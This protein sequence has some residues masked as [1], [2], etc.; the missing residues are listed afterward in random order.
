VNISP[1]RLAF[2][3]KLSAEAEPVH[4]AGRVEHVGSG[5]SARFEAIEELSSFLA[6]ILGQE[7]AA[8]QQKDVE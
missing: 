5:E 7:Q 1:S 3:V 8:P 6:K 2:V 4:L